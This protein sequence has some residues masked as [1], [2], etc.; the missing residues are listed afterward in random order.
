MVDDPRMGSFD[1]VLFGI[2]GDPLLRS[3]ITFVV[4]LDREPDRDTVRDRVDR[5]SRMYPKLRQRADGNPLSI[6]PPRWETDPNF[7][8][9][10]HIRWRR[11]PS[12]QN[13]MDGVLEYAERMGEQDFDRSRPLW[14]VAI[15]TDI[16]VHPDEDGPTS[17]AAFIMKI[18]HA[19]TDGLGGMEMATVLFDLA[20]EPADPGPMPKAPRPHPATV[21]DR[22]RQATR[23]EV[24]QVVGEVTTAGGYA[25]VAAKDLAT[26]PVASVTAAG[27]FTVSAARMLAPQGPPLSKLMTGRS[28]AVSFTTTMVSL[29]ALRDAAT[30]LDATINDV[31]VSA[32]VGGLR[33]YHLAH[34]HDLSGLRVNMPVSVRDDTDVPDVNRWVPARFVIPA[35]VDDPIDR[36][37][38]LRPVLVRAQH[39]PALQ[40]WNAI[41]RLMNVLPGPVTTSVTGVL[42]KGVDF[43][44]TNVP[45]PPV[46]VYLAGARVTMMV[47][48]APK[49]GAAINIAL[50]SYAGQVFIGI[51][52]DR[53]A[54]T[55]PHQLT[56]CIDEAIRA[57][58]SIRAG[59]SRGRDG[60]RSNASATIASDNP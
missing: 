60:Q 11:L 28:L 10:Y 43:A 48:F 3:V 57:V 13:G 50:M 24:R 31:F 18:H 59:G 15:L 32:L 14:E 6:V 54:V 42:M 1:A 40:M 23:F 56:A 55:D 26:A 51:N 41:Y 25:V 52:S 53:A 58:T 12:R 4:L 21:I 35:D 19:I 44:A 34:G 38:E 36:I 45:G 47:P 39:D 5:M 8:F 46:D 17:R 16:D 27:A 9:D 49:A 7:D 30:A 37:R 29:A 22:I 20:P 2:E 33:A